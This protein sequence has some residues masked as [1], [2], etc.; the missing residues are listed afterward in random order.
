MP[1]RQQTLS[2]RRWRQRCSGQSSYGGESGCHPQPAPR[3]SQGDVRFPELGACH[4]H[5]L[6]LGEDP[7]IPCQASV[8]ALPCTVR[9]GCMGG[10]W[11]SSFLLGW[12]K[13]EALKVGSL[14]PS[15][16]RGGW[17]LL[18]CACVAFACLSVGAHAG[19]PCLGSS[20]GH[21][22]VSSRD[23]STMVNTS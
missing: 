11:V 10:P 9:W 20:P 4:P 12:V 14:W 16:G 17:C 21:S 3:V 19:W 5:R 15:H 13:Q 18:L 7:D 1:R 8:T 2:P 22:R 6:L 23:L